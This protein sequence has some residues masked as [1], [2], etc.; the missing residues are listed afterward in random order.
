[1]AFSP[2]KGD[3]GL[4]VDLERL[5]SFDKVT[6]GDPRYRVLRVNIGYVRNEINDGLDVE[7]DPLEDNEAHSL[8]TGKITRG[9]RG[10]LM[11]GATEIVE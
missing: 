7:H 5:S 10:Q 1:M 6:L 8:I 11:K 9:K 4:S 3:K 2:R